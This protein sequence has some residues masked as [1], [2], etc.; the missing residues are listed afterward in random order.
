MVKRDL[1]TNLLVLVL[2]LLT[3]GFL[4]AFVFETYRVQEADQT[5]HLVAGDYLLLLQEAQPDYG[6]LVLYEVDGQEQLGRVMGQAGDQLASV[7]DILYRNQAVLEQPFIEP[8]KQDYL[9]S[10]ATD[11]PF[12]ADFNLDVLLGKPGAR[13]PEGH[14][15]ILKDNRQE[16]ADSREFGPIDQTAIKGVVNFRLLP[17]EQ[18]GFVR[19]D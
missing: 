7:E 5:V 13:V 15:F 10:S 18:F 6:D 8:L 4:R 17:L 1:M 2:V 16:T 3:F 14:Y 9:S 19:T 12:T 11:L